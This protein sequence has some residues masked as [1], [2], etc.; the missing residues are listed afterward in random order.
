MKLLNRIKRWFKK[1]EIE[2]P[3]SIFEIVD[4]KEEKKELAKIKSLKRKYPEADTG[5]QE[6]DNLGQFFK[7]LRSK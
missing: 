3:Q 5:V 6:C 7:D 4:M 2:Q 1:E